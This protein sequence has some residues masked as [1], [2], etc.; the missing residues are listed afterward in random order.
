MKIITYATH[1]EGTFDTLVNSGHDIK[2]LGFGTKWS[3][4]MGKATSVLN[5]LE[6]QRE[7][8][9]VV[10]I[11][12][13]DTIINRNMDGLEEKF[14]NMN[15]KVLYSNNINF[16]TLLL[17]DF[18]SSY[19]N[20]KVFGTCKNNQTLNAGLYMGYCKELKIVLK[21]ILS[22]DM[23][24]DQKA[25][26]SLCSQFPFLKIDTENIIFENSASRNI[27]SKSYFI[28]LPGTLTF[29]RVI[30]AIPEYSKY[31]IPEIL[32]LLCILIFV[33]YNVST[34]CRL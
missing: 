27:I 1:A 29:N 11:D 17:P 30:R 6:T 10:V 18:M 2:V 9:I 3:G 13:F 16:G 12:G 32:F 5:Y 14:I 31:F 8:E 33:I 4:F 34:R 28:G 7:D 19:I 21:A 24:D 22:T 15:C 23:D 26:N 25:V 20:N